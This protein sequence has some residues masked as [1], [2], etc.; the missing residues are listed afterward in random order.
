LSSSRLFPL[1]PRLEFRVQQERCRECDGPLSAL[2]TRTRKVVTLHLGEFIAYES[3]AVCKM[4]H[5]S[6]GSEELLRLVAPGCNFGYDVVV[7]VGKGLFLRHRNGQEIL[8][9]LA[10]RNVN[11]SQSEVYVLGKKFVALLALA[12]RQCTGRIQEAMSCNGGY[13]L[14]LDGTWEGKG[15]LLMTGLDSITEI[16]LGNIKLPS[17][18]AADIIPF[19]EHI[20][21]LFGPPIALVHDMGRGI[22]S[23]VETVFEGVPDFICHYHFLRDLGNDFLQ[24]EYNVIR[25]RLRKLDV[26]SKLG[27]RAREFKKTIDEH[28][29]LIESLRVGFEHGKLSPLFLE[30]LPALNSYSLI[31]WAF[32]AK[33]LGDGYGFPFDRPHLDFANRL[34]SL[35]EYLK[36]L[37]SIE[38]RGDWRDNK[39][40]YKTFSHLRSLLNDK[41]LRRA[42]VHIER[43]IEVF[44]QLRIAMRIAPKNG[45][46]GLNDDALDEPIQTIEKRV[47]C[48]YENLLADSNSR[49]NKDYQR[50]LAQMDKYFEKLF[51]DP[52]EVDTP[53]GKVFLQPQRTNNLLERFF[54]DHKRGHRRKTG[55]RAMNRTMRTM[56]AD[57]PLI[58]NLE[59][60]D[61]MHILLE[62]H[63]NLEALFAQTTTAQLR[64]E[65]Q[66]TQRAPDKIPTVIKRL[67]QAPSYPK[68]L[69]H[70]LANAT[71]T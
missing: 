9:E 54:R 69:T 34:L 64:E 11:I 68:D 1:P 33:N 29:E 15:P 55:H 40:Y 47:R 66:K 48:F 58:K 8:S 10:E 7:Y 35:A 3:M 56:L 17:E 50:L 23:A 4:C 39:P 65:L 2:K 57:T 49:K 6:Y 46:Q 42:I 20:K 59:N 70:I 16:V 27:Y 14:H 25:R 41:T 26:N 30:K 36:Q 52:I 5:S 28:P 44:D 19:L 32:Q 63:E 12:H 18:K 53:E 38:L 22:M 24:S 67:I 62:G 21:E 43:K 37:G 13:M 60:S 61:Y 45:T 51:A 31:Q 71:T